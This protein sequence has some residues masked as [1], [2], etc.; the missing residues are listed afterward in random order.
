MDK[1]RN[2]G[3]H[4]IYQGGGYFRLFPYSLIRHWARK[5]RD[6]LLSYIHPR[7][8]DAGQ[9]M[10]PGLPAAR[11]FKSYV[12]LEGAEKKLRQFLRDFDFTDIATAEAAF[13]WTRART[14]RL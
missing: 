9:P 14:V 13:D 2:S 11:R 4:I 7:D 10:V 1:V 8:L 5:D 12:G 3:S 6:Y